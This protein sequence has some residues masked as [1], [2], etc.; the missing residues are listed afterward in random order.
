MG[1][2]NVA[3]DNPPAYNN[4]LRKKSTTACRANIL[5]TASKQTGTPTDRF[6]I[7]E[8]NTEAQRPQRFVLYAVVFVL[9]DLMDI[10]HQ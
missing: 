6:G 10:R 7:E 5:P 8:M 2:R 4:K 1:I 3:P 9:L